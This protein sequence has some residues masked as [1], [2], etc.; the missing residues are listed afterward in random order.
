MIE[1]R[2]HR[3]YH[4]NFLLLML[5]SREGEEYEQMYVG[6]S[7]SM[8]CNSLLITYFVNICNT[9]LFSFYIVNLYAV[10]KL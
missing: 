4:Y 5:L 8:L 9:S 2:R 3:H 10:L 1:R 6:L 7:E